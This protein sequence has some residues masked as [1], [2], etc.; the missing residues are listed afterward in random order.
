[1]RRRQLIDSTVDAIA[2]RGFAATTLADVST[3]AGCRA[4]S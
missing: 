2:Q 3:G 1:L 4:A